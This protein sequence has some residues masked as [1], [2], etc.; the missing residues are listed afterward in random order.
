MPTGTVRLLVRDVAGLA[1]GHDY[2]CWAIQA[3][4]E[5]YDS[6]SLRRLVSSDGDDV[7][8]A[9]E[10]AA[11]LVG[12]LAEL[13]ITRPDNGALVRDYVREVAREILA[14]SIA[15]QAGADRIHNEVVSAF[16]HPRDLQAWCYL[17]EGVNPGDMRSLSGDALDEAIR[18]TAQVWIASDREHK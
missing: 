6:P 12:V 9:S 16:S 15:P 3:L 10:C 2:V 5:G 11:T 18:K 13:G 8:R 1:T 7:P 4:S 17:S 14:G